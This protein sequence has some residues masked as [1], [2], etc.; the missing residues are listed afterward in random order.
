MTERQHELLNRF[1]DG[2]LTEAEQVEFEAEL[3]ND[4]SLLQMRDDFSAIGN[5]IRTHVDTEATSVSFEGFIDGIDNKLAD[6]E[7]A[8]TLSLIHI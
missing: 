5:M 3:G 8:P 7:P 2:E 6:F 1:L 4:P